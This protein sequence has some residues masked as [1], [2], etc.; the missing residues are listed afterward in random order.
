MERAKKD[1]KMFNFPNVD[2]CTIF[3]SNKEKRSSLEANICITDECYEGTIVF[4]EML[5]IFYKWRLPKELN[6]IR[7]KVQKWMYCI[8]PMLTDMMSMTNGK[9]IH[10]EETTK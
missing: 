3:F 7:M 9:P 6:K 4:V 8:M 5:N 2:R 1:I 10:I